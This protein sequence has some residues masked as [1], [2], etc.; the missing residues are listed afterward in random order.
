MSY[1]SSFCLVAKL[2]FGG[3]EIT[4][5]WGEKSLKIKLGLKDKDPP[6]N[7]DLVP[8]FTLFLFSLFAE[9]NDLICVTV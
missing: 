1:A 4:L 6:T 2:G 7:N 9:G 8:S 3:K 5:T